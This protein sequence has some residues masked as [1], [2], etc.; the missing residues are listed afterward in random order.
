MPQSSITKMS[1][2]I[3]YLNFIQ[4]SSGPIAYLSA[5]DIFCELKTSSVWKPVPYST[6]SLKTKKTE[7][8]IFHWDLHQYVS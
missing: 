1:L 8:I 6:I 5:S 7:N 4:I 2:K 3:T